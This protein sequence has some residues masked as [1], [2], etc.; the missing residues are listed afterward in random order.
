ME[1][2]VVQ[3]DIG[4]L[5]WMIPSKRVWRVLGQGHE[6]VPVEVFARACGAN[7]ERSAA[8]NEVLTASL[9]TAA[10]AMP[11]LPTGMEAW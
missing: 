7:G 2:A 1:R 8:V 9:T 3:K 4:Q 11:E 10:T 6:S 5:F